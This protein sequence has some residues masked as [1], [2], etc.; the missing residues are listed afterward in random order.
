MLDDGMSAT[1]A[2]GPLVLQARSRQ[3][4]WPIVCLL[5]I[6]AGLFWVAYDISATGNAPP[7]GGR[8]RSVG[9]LPP[10]VAVALLAGVGVLCLG[11]A[12]LALKR[13]LFPRLELEIAPAGI[14]SHIMWGRG[15]MRWDEIS[16]LMQNQHGWLFVHGRTDGSSKPKK[17]VVALTQLDQDPGR[18]LA[19]IQ[20]YRPDLLGPPD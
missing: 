18:I 10:D 19:V 5:P 1:G 2:A 17:I 6:A 15:T 9:N 3:P 8:T 20:Y 13:K 12:A 4:W 11:I 14:T 16:H 7:V